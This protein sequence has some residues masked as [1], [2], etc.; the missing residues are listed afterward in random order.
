LLLAN[1]SYELTEMDVRTSSNVVFL[2]QS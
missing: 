1:R 2:E